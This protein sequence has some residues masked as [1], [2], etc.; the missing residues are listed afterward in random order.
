LSREL[1]TL[2]AEDA[3]QPT[4]KFLSPQ[5][6]PDWVVEGLRDAIRRKCAEECPTTH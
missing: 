4:V 1:S 6:I 5:D 2:L 3:P